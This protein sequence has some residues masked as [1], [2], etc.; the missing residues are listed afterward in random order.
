MGKR[1]FLAILAAFTA[2]SSSFLPAL[3][4]DEITSDSTLIIKRETKTISPRAYTDRTD[5]RRIVFEDGCGVASIGEYA[6]LGC[7]SI[8]EIVLPEGLKVVGEGC[9][10]ECESLRRIVFPESITRLPK[11]VCCWCGELREVVVSDK[12]EDIGSHAFAYCGR[13]SGFSFPGGL[14]HIGSNAFSRCC[15]LR[16]VELPASITELESYAFSDCTALES[17]TLPANGKLLGEL[18]FSGCENLR[19][20]VCLS[21]EVPKFDCESFPAEPDDSVFYERCALIVE[22]GMEKKYSSAPG[23]RLFKSIIPCSSF[24]NKF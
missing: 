19:W 10:R 6:F 4:A 5:I 24:P 17:A 9:F 14:L 22:P 8:E 21:G 12:L 11:G 2:L 13:L 15:V 7:G 18:I 1:R 3:A 16:K 20:L 23:W